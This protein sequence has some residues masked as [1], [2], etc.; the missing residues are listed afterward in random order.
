MAPLTT[1]RLSPQRITHP[2]RQKLF[3]P[4]TLPPTPPTTPPQISSIG[5]MIINTNHPPLVKHFPPSHPTHRLRAGRHRLGSRRHRSPIVDSH[6]LRRCLL[7]I[8]TRLRMLFPAPL[9]DNS[10]TRNTSDSI[11]PLPIEPSPLK[12]VDAIFDSYIAAGLIQYF[13]SPW[14][15]P[16][17]RAVKPSDGIRITVNFQNLNKVTEIRQIA[18][19]RDDEVLDILG[20]SPVRSVFDLFLRFNQSTI[21]PDTSSLTVLCTPADLYDWFRS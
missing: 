11:V 3:Q 9:R 17:V 8:K 5:S 10:F 12:Q 7:L 20:G 15:S 13:T 1:C 21:H 14:S 19:P 2:L 16:L 18:T 4:G 6:W